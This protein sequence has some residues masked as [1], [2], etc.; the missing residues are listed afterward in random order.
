MAQ[1]YQD[2]DSTVFQADLRKA[3][4]IGELSRRSADLF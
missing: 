3:L 2:G 4:T 1:M